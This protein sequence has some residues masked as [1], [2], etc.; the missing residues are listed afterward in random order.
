[1]TG[2]YKGSGYGQTLA[3]DA[4]TDHTEF[5]AGHV[6]SKETD[7][8]I[9]IEDRAADRVPGSINPACACKTGLAEIGGNTGGNLGQLDG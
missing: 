3:M 6:E 5:E 1:M 2:F 9:L 8:N 7:M 4:T